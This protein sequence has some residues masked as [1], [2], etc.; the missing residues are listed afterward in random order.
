MRRLLLI[1][2][3]PVGVLVAGCRHD[4]RDLR[5]ARPD[6]NVSIST[7]TSTTIP[8]DSSSSDGASTTAS[9]G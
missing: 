9:G 4:G 2:L 1:T 6:Q 8:V 7:T 3:V 5:P